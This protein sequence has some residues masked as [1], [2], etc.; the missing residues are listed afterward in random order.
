MAND[1]STFWE[2]LKAGT[3][4][5]SEIPRDRWCWED[6]FHANSKAGFLGFLGITT[7]VIYV[8]YLSYFVLIKLGKQGRTATPQ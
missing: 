4:C 8:L 1:L 7:L 3:D 5:I 6:Y 2:R